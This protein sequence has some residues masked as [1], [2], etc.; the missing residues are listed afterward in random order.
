MHYMRT[1]HQCRTLCRKLSARI[2]RSGSFESSNSSS[3]VCWKCG[4]DM[5]GLCHVNICPECGAVVRRQQTARQEADE[6]AVHALLSMSLCNCVLS[7]VAIAL[8][9]WRFVS[10]GAPIFY[11]HHWLPELGQILSPFIAIWSGYYYLRLRSARLHAISSI[12]AFL[13]QSAAAGILEFL[14]AI[15]LVL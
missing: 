9:G 1:L 14:T 8:T 15:A 5:D 10:G 7:L 6:D 2:I 3:R 4:Y 12:G 13:A 11:Q